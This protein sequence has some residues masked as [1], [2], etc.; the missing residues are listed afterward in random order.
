MGIRLQL[1]VARMDRPH[2]L[3]TGSAAGV[4]FAVV[5]RA[6][7][8]FADTPA[9]LPPELFCPELDNTSRGPSSWL[10]CWWDWWLD[11]ALR[12]LWPVEPSST[13]LLSGGLLLSG[14]PQRLVTAS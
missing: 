9:T 1:S 2:A 8:R 10:V 6:L 14:V 12:G 5:L 11:P 4:S 7:Q 13:R 3:Q